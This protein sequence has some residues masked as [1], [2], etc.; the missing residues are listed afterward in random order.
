MGA[1]KGT[2]LLMVW[3]DVEMESAWDVRLCTV[4]LTVLGT[5]RS[6]RVSNAGRLRKPGPSL[7]QDAPLA[8]RGR[9]NTVR[10]RII[11]R[12]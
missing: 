6:S 9:P 4:V 1:L 12:R 5:V 8:L 2:G 11:E 3:A 10:R 7:R